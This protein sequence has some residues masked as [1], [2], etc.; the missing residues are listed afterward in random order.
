[1][2]DPSLRLKNGFAHD[3][4]IIKLI[5]YQITKSSFQES[6]HG[7]HSNADQRRTQKVETRGAQEDEGG[8][9]E[10]AARLRSRIE[11]AQGEEVGSRA[12]EAVGKQLAVST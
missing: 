11:E 10:E 8:K 9:A 12:V 3:D 5:D 7:K 2:G 6:N 4:N 1:V